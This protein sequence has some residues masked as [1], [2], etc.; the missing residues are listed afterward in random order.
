M[1]GQRLESLVQGNQIATRFL[2]QGQVVAQGDSNG[3]GAPF[4]VTPRT[5]EINENPAHQTSGHG[6][7]VRAVLPADAAALDQTDIYLVDERGCLKAMPLSFS[8]H[9]ATSDP[10]EFVVNDGSKLFEGRVIA[11]SPSDEEFRDV[12]ARLARRQQLLLNALDVYPRR[13]RIVAIFSFV[14]AQSPGRFRRMSSAVHCARI[15]PLEV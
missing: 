9:S 10:M 1:P 6:E 5:G 8:G 2:R 7:E 13:F 12:E 15:K 4:L 14:S 3:T 11:L